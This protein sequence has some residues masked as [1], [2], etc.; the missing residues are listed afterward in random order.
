VT[1]TEVARKAKL[2][3]TSAVIEKETAVSVVGDQNSLENNR[4]ELHGGVKW[5][6]GKKRRGGTCYQ[7]R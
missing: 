6:T 4:K 5:R 3:D 7:A 1:E 2:D